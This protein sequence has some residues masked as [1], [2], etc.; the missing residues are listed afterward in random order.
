[1]EDEKAAKLAQ[2]QLDAEARKKKAAEIEAQAKAEQ[3]AAAE[4]AA[5]AAT[6]SKKLQDEAQQE[7]LK[8]EAEEKRL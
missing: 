3:Q 5:K 7:N 4:R 8:R 1:M 6:A 2:E